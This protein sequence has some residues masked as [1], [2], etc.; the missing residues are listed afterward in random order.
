MVLC[1]RRVRQ[2]NSKQYRLRRR[3]QEW[4]YPRHGKKSGHKYTG[5]CRE[6]GSRNCKACDRPNRTKN[7]HAIA[8]NCWRGD[9]TSCL[10]SIEHDIKASG[11]SGLAQALLSDSANSD[12]P[13]RVA[14]WSS[15]QEEFHP[16]PLTEPY[17]ILSHHTAL[18]IQSNFYS[19]LPMIKHPRTCQLYFLI[20]N[21]H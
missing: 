14:G 7:L 1:G 8:G 17:L 19:V 4:V 6:P 10:A 20:L 13:A 11:L 5:S 12:L 18:V 15:R 3:I 21:I 16:E 9:K 2:L